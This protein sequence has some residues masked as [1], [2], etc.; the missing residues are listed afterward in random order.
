MNL[1]NVLD[2]AVPFDTSVFLSG[3]A[4]DHALPLEANPLTQPPHLR[5]LEVV[6]KYT[7]A[8]ETQA[9]YLLDLSFIENWDS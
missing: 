1:R 9:G 2:M 8:E 3:L 6:F 4:M 5:H 7:A